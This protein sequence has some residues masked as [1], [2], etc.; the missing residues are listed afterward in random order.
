MEIWI[1]LECPKCGTAN[2]LQRGLF[3]DHIDTVCLCITKVRCW[4]CLHEYERMYD[5]FD[6]C[7]DSKCGVN[8]AV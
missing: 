2:W 1:K 3:E 4:H 8:E 7:E 5:H 6:L